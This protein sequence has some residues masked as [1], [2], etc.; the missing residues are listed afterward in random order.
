MVVKKLYFEYLK[1]EK[2]IERHLRGMHLVEHCHCLNFYIRFLMSR[3]VLFLYFDGFDGPF[4]HFELSEK[5]IIQYIKENIIKILW[6]SLLHLQLQFNEVIKLC[7]LIFHCLYL[8]I[9]WKINT[10]M[11]SDRS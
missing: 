7:V 10:F 1:I 5:E 9:E 6:L 4:F 2:S 8:S 11:Q 3:R